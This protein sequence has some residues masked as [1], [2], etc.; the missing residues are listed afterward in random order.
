MPIPILAVL[1]TAI[2]SVLSAMLLLVIAVGGD[3]P[4][5]DW[6]TWASD[7]DAWDVEPEA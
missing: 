2:A 1:A 4:D 7:R 6:R 5:D 3:D